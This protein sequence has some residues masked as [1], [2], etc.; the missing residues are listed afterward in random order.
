MADLRARIL[1]INKDLSLTPDEKQ[2]RIR[3]AMLG[4]TRRASHEGAGSVDE[5]API[6]PS[7]MFEWSNSGY[8]EASSKHMMHPSSYTSIHPYTHL[9]TRIVAT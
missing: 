7:A 4:S 3:E 5:P 6:D 8:F 9:H 2:T 1:E